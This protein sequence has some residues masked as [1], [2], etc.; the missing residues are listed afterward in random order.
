MKTLRSRRMQDLFLSDELFAW[1]LGIAVIVYGL[2]ILGSGH[3]TS[4]A[5]EVVQDTVR[6]WL[7]GG[8]MVAAGAIIILFLSWRDGQDK[9]EI[10]SGTNK[11]SGPESH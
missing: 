10:T 8:L 7:G 3:Y 2:H 1:A 5:G 4:R 6:V 9:D 11:P